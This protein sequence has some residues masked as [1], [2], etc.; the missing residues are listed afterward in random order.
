MIQGNL[1]FVIW[2]RAHDTGNIEVAVETAAQPLE[3]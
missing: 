3:A 1:S 2:G